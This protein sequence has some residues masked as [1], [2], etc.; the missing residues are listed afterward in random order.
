MGDA[1]RA[2]VVRADHLEGKSLM[3]VASITWQDKIERAEF[4]SS[5]NN[6]AGDV[7]RFYVQI[8]QFQQEVQTRLNANSNDVHQLVPIVPELLDLLAHAGTPQ[9]QEMAVAATE[10]DWGTELNSY[11]SERADQKYT[12]LSFI[13]LT[14]LQP[15][16]HLLADKASHAERLINPR[17]PFC[18]CK[19]QLGVLRPEGD[20]GKRFLLCSLCGAE[21]E[22][23]R[24][25]CPNCEE[26]DK[27]KLPI[28]KSEELVYIK[29]AAC[30]TCHTYLKC[31]DLSTN[32]HA[33]PEIDDV[34][35]LPISL[36]MVDKGFQPIRLNLFGF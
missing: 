6:A 9:M 4:L 7:L 19:P 22:Y 23:R 36:W 24:V 33:I 1:A 34:A 29:L 8:L 3:K 12:R 21:W 30:D 27:E 11:W 25:I 13:A 17:C 5:Q 20:G 15:F 10:L 28:Y 26:S 32:G 35:S 2:E 16:A 31:I 14:M 18:G